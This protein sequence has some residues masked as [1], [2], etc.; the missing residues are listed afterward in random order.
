[1]AIA[2]VG[3]RL[4]KAR[5]RPP[6]SLP[7][8]GAFLVVAAVAFDQG[9]YF[10]GPWG[11]TILAAA[12]AAAVA[13]VGG[14]RA[15]LARPAA[16]TAAL[17]AAF[18]AWTALS[19]TWSLSPTQSALETQR[20]AV[21]AAAFLAAALWVRRSP[22]RLLTGVWAAVS[23]VCG[24]SLLTRLV[25][26]RF[27]V[28]YVIS[29]NR[30]SAPVGYWN[31]LGLFAAIG[32][33]LALALAHE[34]ASR[35]TRALAAAT[36]PLLL[37]TLYFTYSRGAWL[38][39]GFGLAVALAASARRVRLGAA[40]VVLAPWAA[41]AVWRAA[42]MRPL[43]IANPSLAAAAHDG[44][45][46]VLF[47]LL[48]SACSGA[49]AWWLAPLDARLVLPG[50]W[51]R[52]TRL[53]GAALAVVALI[54]VTVAFGSPATI[55]SKTWHAFAGGGGAGGAT[56]NSRLFSFSGSGRVTQ[57]RIAWQEVQA[58]PIVGTGA[59]TSEISWNR[60]RPTASHVR[61]VH[62][63]YLQALAEL[64]VIGLAFL[65]LAL[66]VPLVAGVAS[67]RRPLLAGVLGAYAAYLLHGAVDW[68]WEITGV[69]LPAIVCAAVLTRRPA[70]PLGPRGRR[71]ALA[72][73]AVLAAGGI[74]T[75]AARLPLNRLDTALARQ[76]WANA[77]HDAHQAARL[78][79]W[80]SEPYLKLGEAE[81]AYGL[82]PEAHDAFR[83][84]V[85]RDGNN[86]VAWWDL[87]QASR[88]GE[89]TDALL[90]VKLLNPL[91]PPAAFP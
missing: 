79:P 6:R 85:D 39:L 16:A 84:A 32:A 44:H 20:V 55:A 31:S 87:A 13:L 25:P 68:D 58:H 90:H 48:A 33:L 54:G 86:W 14:K 30:L 47:L 89:R 18:T 17:L 60:L 61:D 11:W 77:T 22:E 51:L 42:S 53:A 26:D 67:R 50:T 88:G 38:S 82:T 70:R 78:A 2:R 83:S 15:R 7:A 40:I 81:L 62:N 37:T 74:Y 41:V 46:L 66:L 69:T 28:D 27:G 59:R 3:V 56:L 71:V 8:A 19:T 80:S 57:W 63:L 4:L 65:S 76:E 75:I 91:A 23:V 24:W 10:P 52:A 35:L 29:G 43:T 49:A 21:Y 72:G 73:V 36:L 45:R 5:G 1:M 34:S 9:G 64:G 12:W